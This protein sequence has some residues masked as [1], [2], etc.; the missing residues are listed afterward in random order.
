MWLVEYTDEFG[1]WWAML[2]ET[3]Q[4]DLLEEH[5]P[6]LGRPTVDTIE[7]SRHLNMKEL[8]IASNG[9]LRVLFAFDPRRTAIR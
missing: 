5:G 9:Q 1:E 3:Q 4:E 7:G 2:A 8:R 6:A